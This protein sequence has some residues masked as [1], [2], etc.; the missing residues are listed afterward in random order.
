MVAGTSVHNG[1]GQNQSDIPCQDITL[2]Q[3]A[4]N[5]GMEGMSIRALPARL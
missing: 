5:K 1:G 4:P 2:S 3:N